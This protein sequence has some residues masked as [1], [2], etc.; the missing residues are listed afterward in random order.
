MDIAAILL[1]AL[2]VAAIVLA[3]RRGRPAAGP[4]R[5][6]FPVTGHALPEPALDAALRLAR[7]ER[8]TLVPVFLARV[9]MRLALDAPLP[10]EPL[11]DAV[12]RRAAA[13]GVPVDPRVDR[14]RT[15][16]HALR[17]AIAHERFDRLVVAAGDGLDSGDLAWLLDHAPGEVVII[18]VP[19]EEGHGRS[20]HRPQPLAG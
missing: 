17:E 16:R 11:L 9:P 10:H 8:A 5:F 18:R 6:L 15:L 3:R 7:A 20:G 12:E 14:G 1:A 19:E 13:A 2:A 4:R